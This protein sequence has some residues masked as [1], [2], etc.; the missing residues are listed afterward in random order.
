MAGAFAPED[1]LG[2]ASPIEL[3]RGTRLGRYELLVPIA[4]GGMARVWAARQHGQRGFTKLVAIKTILP[5]LAREGE[6]ER[7]FL[8]EARIASLVHHPNVCEIYEL[9]DDQGVLYLAMEWVSGD[10]LMHVLRNAK[11]VESID[12]RIAARIVA[13]GAAGLHAAHELTDDDNRP[14]S[15]VHRDVSPHN[16]LISGDGHIKVADFGVAKA[17]GQMHS[18]T[19]AGQIKG[20]IAYMAPE[21][22]TSTKVDRRSD[23]FSLGCILYEATTGLQPFLGDS[24]PQVMHAIMKGDYVPPSTLMIG[25]P[26]DLENIIKT[27]LSADVAGR[28]ATADQMKLALEQWLAVSGPIVSTSHVAALVKE[29]IGPVLEKRREKIRDASTA[30]S[31]ESLNATPG[32][33]LPAPGSTSGVREHNK[34]APRN[35]SRPDSYPGASGSSGSFP[36]NQSGPGHTS[37]SGSGNA[38]SRSQAPGPMSP[39]G[40][41]PPNMTGAVHDPG[42][43]QHREPSAANFP[44][45]NPH[46]AVTNYGQTSYVPPNPPAQNL[47]GPNQPGLG[48]FNPFA[49]APAGSP[50]RYLIGIGIGIAVALALAIVVVVIMSLTRKTPAS[51]ASASS[52]TLAATPNTQPTIAPAVAGDIPQATATPM[53][54]ATQA[55]VATV[56]AATPPANQPVATQTAAAKPASP[57]PQATHAPTATAHRPMPLPLPNNTDPN[58]N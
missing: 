20:K 38:P 16:I 14:M 15:V 55:P 53:P 25:Y 46:Q 37:D 58:A 7:M 48:G 22:I 5:H 51:S 26:K 44:P 42:P 49:A 40:M 43:A 57:P 36:G 33:P 50:L 21:Q 13:D 10:S 29:R 18:A 1:E 41:T 9:G 3:R 4:R 19:I 39:P 27:A 31:G 54:I 32:P 8:D 24:D 52:S 47:A 56:Q 6:F 23:I 35:Q 45:Y 17:L 34:D 11:R 28:Y 30:Q 12:L 2:E